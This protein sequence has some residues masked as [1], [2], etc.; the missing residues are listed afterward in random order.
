MQLYHIT[1]VANCVQAFKLIAS[2]S[3]F[4]YE[5]GS[6][7]T[8]PYV[9]LHDI[10]PPT[11]YIHTYQICLRSILKV[12]VST[13]MRDCTVAE[14]ATSTT[15]KSQAKLTFVL[16]NIWFADHVLVAHT[17]LCGSLVQDGSPAPLCGRQPSTRACSS[18][19]RLVSSYRRTRLMKIVRCFL[20][21]NMGKAQPMDGLNPFTCVPC[22]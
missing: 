17:S 10:V 4:F 9:Q 21:R 5:C 20:D 19:L 12:Q 22:F 7:E 8:C 2:S 11:S 3:L 13:D 18:S 15:E 14:V 6:T 16:R 1:P